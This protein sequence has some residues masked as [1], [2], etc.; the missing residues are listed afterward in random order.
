MRLH[1]ISVSVS[2]FSAFGGLWRP[3]EVMSQSDELKVRIERG[4]EAMLLK[5]QR[6]SR[7]RKA[8]EGSCAQGSEYGSPKSSI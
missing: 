4:G 2:S 1:K 7:V 3:T 5:S 8:P 6:G